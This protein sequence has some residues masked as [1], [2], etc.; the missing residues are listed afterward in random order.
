LHT[1]CDNSQEI[2]KQLEVIYPSV[3][4]KTDLNTVIYNDEI[5]GVVISVPAALHYQIARQALLAGKNVFV[6]KPLALTV[7]DGTEL[8]KLAEE[9]RRY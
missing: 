1:V 9:K 8:V 3:N 6:E 4:K 7:S 2:L 5:E